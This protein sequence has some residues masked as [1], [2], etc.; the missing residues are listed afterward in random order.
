MSGSIVLLEMIC[1]LFLAFYRF[2]PSPPTKKN[3][4]SA[5]RH[6][7]DDR[8]NFYMLWLQFVLPAC[9]S[10]P[11]SQQ[12]FQYVNQFSPHGPCARLSALA[13]C[14]LTDNE[15]LFCV[16]THT[17]CCSSQACYF[18]SKH[19]SIDC[20]YH[21]CEYSPCYME[22]PNDRKKTC[23]LFSFFSALPVGL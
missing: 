12:R 21:V 7:S 5:N 22:P 11:E 9:L 23:R 2:L 4:L 6:N 18:L 13:G 14:V 20:Y 3:N 16:R 15:T 17:G 10:A 1:H 8:C 19:V